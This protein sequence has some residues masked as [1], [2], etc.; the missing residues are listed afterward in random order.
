M[1]RE[2]KHRRLID[3]PDS[4]DSD[5][6]EFPAIPAAA[7]Y[8]QRGGQETGEKDEDEEQVLSS[9]VTVSHPEP[10]ARAKR[11]EDC[12]VPLKPPRQPYNDTFQQR[13]GLTVRAST[14]RKN[15]SGKLTCMYCILFT[16][17]LMIFIGEPKCLYFESISKQECY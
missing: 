8:F 13:L 3:E 10:I 17:C 1:V 11:E 4:S 7:K 14:E 12:R 2:V 16:I 6:F 9:F 15:L 5:D